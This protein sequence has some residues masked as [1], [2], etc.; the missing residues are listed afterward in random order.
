MSD[1]KPTCET[2]DYYE[3]LAGDTGEVVGACCRYAPKPGYLTYDQIRGQSE[4]GDFMPWACWPRTFGTNT[5]G[6]HSLW[7]KK[8]KE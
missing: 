3:P 4:I 6:D 5:C 1:I 7:E 8:R 2:C